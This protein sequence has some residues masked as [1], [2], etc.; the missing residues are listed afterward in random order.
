MN[1][2]ERFETQRLVLRKP[3]PSD[4]TVFGQWYASERRIRQRGT[5]TKVEVALRFAAELGLWQ[6]NGY[7]RYMVED[8]RGRVIG[9]VG[10]HFPGGWPAPELA[11][12]LWHDDVEGQGFAFEATRACLCEIIPRLAL[13]RL[14]SIIRP[15][16]TRSIALA[17]RL[18]ATPGE[19]VNLFGDQEHQLYEHDLD[20][21]ERE[22][23]IKEAFA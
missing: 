5:E 7:G 18:G 20:A 1:S 9:M 19:M 16:N 2:M 13:P 8:K 4:T 14:A 10:P 12:H 3:K 17:L 23:N 21:W 11:W 22:P 15:N 6:I